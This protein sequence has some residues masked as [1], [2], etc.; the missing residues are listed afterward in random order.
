ML[1]GGVEDLTELRGV[2]GV[3]AV[4]CGPVDDPAGFEVVVGPDPAGVLFGG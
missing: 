2:S 4:G 1:M 3:G